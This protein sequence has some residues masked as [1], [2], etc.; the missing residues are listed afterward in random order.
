MSMWFPFG[1]DHG[2]LASVGDIVLHGGMPFRDGWDMKGP[3]AYLPF[4]L[5]QLIF[6]RYLW[7][8]RIFDLTL[9]LVACISLARMIGRL[10]TPSVGAWSG[11]ALFLSYASFGYFFTAQPD[12]WAGLAMMAGFAPLIGVSGTPRTR[13]LALCGVFI[14]LST[15]VKPF[16]ATFILVPAI[17]LIADL[18]QQTIR[19]IAN[20]FV[21]LG[22]GF[23][24]PIALC[25]SWFAANGA[26][27]DFY[28]VHFL[29]AAG[30]YS[31]VTL[32]VRGRMWGS[33]FAWGGQFA[34]LLP[35]LCVGLWS[36]P[37]AGTP[38]RND[39][40]VLVFCRAFRSRSPG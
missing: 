7:S 2:I 31:D 18:G 5:V 22:A 25:L 11:L 26:L 23:V 40:A 9:L 28:S 27:G 12:G 21:A 4:T 16:Y 19:R 33:Q 1:W 6:G 38:N 35:M 37:D 3:V 24:F 17:D 34:V 39:A 32:G 29:Y 14:G 13:Q 30:E 36:A 15:L 10:S 20:G 8:I